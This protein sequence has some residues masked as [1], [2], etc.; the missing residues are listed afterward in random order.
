MGFFKTFGHEA[1]AWGLLSKGAKSS[2]SKG[3][4][5]P[6]HHAVRDRI[7]VHFEIGI[8]SQPS[9]WHVVCITDDG[10]L[11]ESCRHINH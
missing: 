11:C 5:I 6:G 2:L 1:F 7:Q 3:K 4:G 9:Q 8:G 10:C